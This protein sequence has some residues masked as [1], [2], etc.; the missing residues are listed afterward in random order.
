VLAIGGDHLQD[1]IDAVHAALDSPVLRPHFEVIE[2]KRVGRRFGRRKADPKAAA[3]LIDA[4]TVMS[5]SE[6]GKIA[7]ILAAAPPALAR[8]PRRRSRARPSHCP[9]PT[10]PRRP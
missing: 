4:K 6:V 10:K 5:G 8:M 2:A 1:G 7:K 3:E 9:C